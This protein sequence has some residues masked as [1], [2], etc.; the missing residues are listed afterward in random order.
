MKKPNK[1]GFNLWDYLYY[2]TTLLYSKIEK[3]AGFE[4]NKDTGAYLVTVML[5]FNF[6]GLL[7]IIIGLVI[8]NVFVSFSKHEYFTYIIILLMITYSI[9]VSQI[10]KK[11]HDIIFEKYEKETEKEKK[12]RGMILIFYIILSTIIFFVSVFILRE[13]FLSNASTNLSINIK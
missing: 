13:V 7:L 6:Y 4:Y 1:K 9:I 5:F 2:R 11:R 8:P 3:K 10:M 12:V